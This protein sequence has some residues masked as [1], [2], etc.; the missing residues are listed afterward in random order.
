MNSSLVVG[1][2]LHFLSYFLP[3][4]WRF[5]GFFRFPFSSSC[6]F[7]GLFIHISWIFGCLSWKSNHQCFEHGFFFSF[8]I[9]LVWGSIWYFGRIFKTS[10][11][12]R[13]KLRYG[14]LFKIMIRSNLKSSCKLS[15][16]WGCPPRNPWNLFSCKILTGFGLPQWRNPSFDLSSPNWEIWGFTFKRN[17]L[18]WLDEFHRRSVP[19][20]PEFY[21]VI[22]C[23]EFAP[24]SQSSSI[25]LHHRMKI[26]L[27]FSS[28]IAWGLSVGPR[29]SD[30]SETY[31]MYCIVWS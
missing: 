14:K 15:K 25:I 10:F 29:W 13:G 24:V 30:F 8:L 19:F 26:H 4:F 16:T 11:W 1:D 5:F 23:S 22:D 7:R 2:S 21:V 20:S 28:L 17:D 9:S 6:R 31:C 18:C 3:F 27:R 12:N